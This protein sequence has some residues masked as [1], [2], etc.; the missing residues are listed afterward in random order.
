M[1]PSTSGSFAFGL[2]ATAVLSAPTSL[3]AAPASLDSVNVSLT[4]FAIVAAPIAG[5]E[6]SQLQI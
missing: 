6:R 5:S 4:Q 1:A 2:L 3:R